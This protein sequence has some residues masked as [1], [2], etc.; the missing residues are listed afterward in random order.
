MTFTDKSCEIDLEDNGEGFTKVNS[1]CFDELDK[2][3]EEKVRYNFHP[4]GQGRL[5]IVF[6]ADS[7]L[8]ETVFMNENGELKKR[9]SLIQTHKTEYIALVFLITKKHPFRIHIQESTFK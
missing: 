4:L 6:F 8:Y 9:S 1:D 2:K 7:S 5:A 3:N